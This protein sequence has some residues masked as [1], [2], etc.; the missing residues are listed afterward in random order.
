[1]DL[2]LAGKVVVVT[3]ASS[4]IGAALVTAFVAEGA[5]VVGVARR[6]IEEGPNVLSAQ[7]D[8]RVP[9][10]LAR[11][12]D[13]A[14]ARFGRV[15]VAVA[16]AGIWPSDDVPLAHMDPTRVR[17]VVDVNLHGVLWTAQAFVRA[18]ERTGPRVDG[19]GA[20]L[21]LIGSTAG[22]F[23]E[24]GHVEYAA[25]KAALHGVMKTLKN[26]LV[27]VDPAARVNLVEPGWTATPMVAEALQASGDV[28][29][30]TRTMPLRRLATPEDVAAAVLFFASPRAARHVSGEAL[31]VAGG[32]EGRVLW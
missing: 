11:A 23:G 25:T 19:D 12:F 3:G 5:S 29:R 32:M 21:V 15:D 28:A 26:E 24:R 2:G 1:M 27:L 13:A 30:V 10:Q 18:L 31:T 22:L 16:N 20:S 7:A 4:G 14:L 6:A 8:V 9:E 17:E